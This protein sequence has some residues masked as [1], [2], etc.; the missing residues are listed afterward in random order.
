MA[1]ISVKIMSI[2]QKTISFAEN[3]EIGMHKR[4]RNLIDYNI[5]F[6]SFDKQL[7]DRLRFGTQDYL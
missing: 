4:S 7:R 2:L 6:A 1:L 3:K 5:D